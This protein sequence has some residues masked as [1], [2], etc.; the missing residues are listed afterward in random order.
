MGTGFADEFDVTK[1]RYHKLILMGRR[2]RRGAH[3][4]PAADVPVPHMKPL[5]EAGYVYLA[6]PPLYQIK[7]SKRKNW[8]A[9][10]SATRARRDP[11]GPPRGRQ[12]R[13]PAVQGASRASARW[14]LR[15][16][17]PRDFMPTA[18]RPRWT[19]SGGRCS[20]SPMDD[21]AAA[22]EMFSILM[23][24]DVESRVA[25]SSRPT[26]TRRSTSRWPVPRC[27]P[28]PRALTVPLV[29][30]PAGRTAPARRGGWAVPRAR[31]DRGRAGP[32]RPGGARRD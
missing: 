20:W 2:R 4:H 6:Q 1:A 3:P 15:Q 13:R 25:T 10:A 7:H 28:R 27:G 18:T 23:G 11:R 22:D 17:P 26:P 12:A 19:P 8:V 30:R 16:L 31:G 29:L 5:I 32:P 9:Y 24:D 14:T 21:A